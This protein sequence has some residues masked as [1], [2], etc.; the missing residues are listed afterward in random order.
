M[1][2]LHTSIRH[3]TTTDPI[4]LCPEDII[5]PPPPD[6][7]DD[8]DAERRAR[9]RRRI[10]TIANHYI[11]L[12][13]APLIV[14]A[15]LRGPFDNGW[16]NPWA[17]PPSLAVNQAGKARK[18]TDTHGA[19]GVN[20]AH[21]Q[22]RN[23]RPTSS[24]PSPE[25]LRGLD[26][27][28]DS[29]LPPDD[30]EDEVHVAPADS[31]ASLDNTGATEPL[32]ID[33]D[34]SITFES[35]ESNPFWLKRPLPKSTASR[36]S[37]CGNHDPSPT[38]ARLGS[39]PV[40]QQGRLQLVTPKQPIKLVLPNPRRNEQEPDW[41]STASA[42]MA[43]TSPATP[44]Q[45][46]QEPISLSTSTKRKRTNSTHERTN[47]T[48]APSPTNTLG[49]AAALPQ[50]NG[51]ISPSKHIVSAPEICDS[52]SPL[53]SAAFNIISPGAEVTQNAKG[54]LPNDK[55][56]DQTST[57]LQESRQQ[58][59]HTSVK[60][61]VPT[62]PSSSLTERGRNKNMTMASDATP[63]IRHN[64]VT[65]PTCAS[66]TG[67]I[68]RKIGKSKRIKSSNE[69][70]PQPQRFSSPAKM[71]QCSTGSTRQEE[72]PVLESHKQDSITTSEPRTERADIYDVPGSPQVQQQSCR[73][74]RNSGFS[75][76]A[77]LLLA[78]M[79]FQNGTM[80]SATNSNTT[81]WLHAVDTTPHEN[82]TI[83]SPAFTPFHKFNATLEAE[84]PP[85]PA[86][87]EMPIS[88]Q[89]LFAT[90]SPFGFS[91]VKRSARPPASNMRFS[92]FASQEQGTPSYSGHKI[93]P[94]SPTPSQRMP[95]KAKNVTVSF[96]GSRPEKGSQ[97]EK[98]SQESM[99]SKA[100]PVQTAE[101]PQLDFH[102]S[103]DDLRRNDDLNFT[104][105][106]LLNFS[107]MT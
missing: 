5:E 91:T 57:T 44:A 96:L 17:K 87:H 67:F 27:A 104:D 102:N 50:M 45:I 19:K 20:A 106:F 56:T 53:A 62:G 32:G 42:S 89:D 74:S 6:E 22:T 93:H 47:A 72:C 70:N 46:I 101:L 26:L 76:Q 49:S 13:R 107:E 94:K 40:D 30:T 75:T 8:H 21:I 61:C 99:A 95:L 4:F 92:V 3:V 28:Q 71:D 64:H 48:G 2:R 54:V 35:F 33:P 18:E 97:S 100:L 60:R 63:A 10:E 14:S 65:S 36:N 55:V 31:T 90:I 58:D 59:T 105:R 77:A 84:Y 66:S 23:L 29:V 79:E 41:M 25:T 11:R 43:I 38:R 1:P 52:R 39:R 85:E 15:G 81:P 37:P 69:P 78:Q 68:Y 34:P 103:M 16:K 98:G 9:K 12:G 83:P 7:D 24:V 86:M 80:T 82:P 51:Q 88:T 73:S